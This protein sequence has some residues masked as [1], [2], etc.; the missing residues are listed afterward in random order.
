MEVVLEEDDFVEVGVI[1]VRVVDLVEVCIVDAV[2][3]I[4][5][6][7]VMEVVVVQNIVVSV[8]LGVVD[9]AEREVVESIELVDISILLEVVRGAVVL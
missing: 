2:L 5:D 9:A 6:L 8:D 7:V 4:D 1:V 3:E